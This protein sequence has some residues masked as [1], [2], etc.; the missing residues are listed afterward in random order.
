MSQENNIGKIEL[1]QDILRNLGYKIDNNKEKILTKNGKIITEL[2][3]SLIC[4]NKQ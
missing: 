1:D 4:E 2:D 3:L